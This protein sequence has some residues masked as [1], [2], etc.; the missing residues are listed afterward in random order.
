MVR[1][2]LVLFMVFVLSGCAGMN[3]GY[4]DPEAGVDVTCVTKN[5]ITSCSYVGPDGKEFFIDA[6]VL[7]QEIK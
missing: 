6:P 4:K 1:Y 5:E 3:F 2:I 7:G